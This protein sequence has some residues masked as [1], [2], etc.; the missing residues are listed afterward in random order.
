MVGRIFDFVGCDWKDNRKSMS[1][2]CR[3]FRDI[4]INTPKYWRSISNS[5]SVEN[6]ALH[7][8]RS[9]GLSLDV[10]LDVGFTG[11]RDPVRFLR[12]ILVE[13]R[14]W[15]S[16]RLNAFHGIA[17]WYDMG[18]IHA[19]L[20]G[21]S[22]PKLESVI[23]EHLGHRPYANAPV[24]NDE[25]HFYIT[26]DAPSVKSWYSTN[27]FPRTNRTFRLEEVTIDISWRDRFDT[28]KWSTTQ[29]GEFLS[30]QPCI[31]TLELGLTFADEYGLIAA[32][33]THV[34]P[35]L[36]T[37]R[38]KDMSV[39]TA[40][41]RPIKDILRTLEMPSLET[42]ELR[43]NDDD[44]TTRDLEEMFSGG[45]FTNLKNFL[46]SITD[47]NVSLEV[48]FQPLE[49]I[50]PNTPNLQYLRLESPHLKTGLK[51]GLLGNNKP[52]LHTVDIDSCRGV[53]GFGVSEF[54]RDLHG[55]ADCSEFELL[56]IGRGLN[57]DVDWIRNS[58]KG[59]LPGLK[60]YTT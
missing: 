5:F 21:L 48:P 31:E 53:T 30:E 8:T 37:L 13:H 56:R 28:F 42:L 39:P 12:T 25:F 60:V 32:Q 14:R 58:V 26:W 10:T 41:T 6:V 34:I 33:G 16:F 38:F 3:R 7:M 23:I 57:V 2:V 27:L 49:S 17:N 20:Q 19:L 46:F 52:P 45:R 51:L 55:S 59:Y 4:I 29:L 9:R 18:Q 35:T 44:I 47:N 43:I 22:L 36:R 50:L 54:V 1:L 15:Q 40:P 24:D 11:K